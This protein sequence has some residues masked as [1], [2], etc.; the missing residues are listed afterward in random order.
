MSNVWANVLSGLWRLQHMVYGVPNRTAVHGNIYIVWVKTA[1]NYVS[2]VG[3]GN[4]QA[5][6]VQRWYV[7]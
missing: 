1:L 3:F 5:V 6:V 2:F 4:K 7:S